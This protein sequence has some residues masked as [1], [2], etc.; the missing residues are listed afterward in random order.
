MGIT[1]KTRRNQI[2]KLITLTRKNYLHDDIKKTER[3]RLTRIAQERNG[4]RIE[5]WR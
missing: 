5:Q 1:Q 3:F 2:F 4:A